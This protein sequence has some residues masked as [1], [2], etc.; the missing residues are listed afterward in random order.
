MKMLFSINKPKIQNQENKNTIIQKSVDQQNIYQAT[1]YTLRYGMFAR[2]LNTN[3][4]S[5]DK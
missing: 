3:C 1:V 5:C 2:M 4:S